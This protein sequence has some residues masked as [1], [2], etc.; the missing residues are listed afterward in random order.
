MHAPARAYDSANAARRI[1]RAF[2]AADLAMLEAE[3]EKSAGLLP[4]TA[5][6]P[7]D[8]AERQELLEAVAQAM[9]G[10]LTHVHRRLGGRLHAGE[11][12]LALLRHL[13]RTAPAPPA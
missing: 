11:V 3:L 7:P 8:E 6:L 5:S 9:R 13:A 10:A 12:H 1:L 2:G 4:A